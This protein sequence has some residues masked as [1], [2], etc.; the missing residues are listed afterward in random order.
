M[1]YYLIAVTNRF[2]TAQCEPTFCLP[3]I[4]SATLFYVATKYVTCIFTSV[5][6]RVFHLNRYK[7]TFTYFEERS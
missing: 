4:S 5:V 2:Q 3:L 6:E 7:H 1:Q